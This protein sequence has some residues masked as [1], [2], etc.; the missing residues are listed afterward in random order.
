VLVKKIATKQYEMQEK[1]TLIILGV[2]V[3]ILGL[4][5]LFTQLHPH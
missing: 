4:I 3:A 5:V 2:I 1:R